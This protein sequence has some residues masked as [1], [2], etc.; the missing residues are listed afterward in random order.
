[1]N[2][3]EFNQCLADA[4]FFTAT[5]CFLL[6]D[7]DC[8][9]SARHIVSITSLFVPPRPNFFHHASYIAPRY[10]VHKLNQCTTVFSTTLPISKAPQDLPPLNEHTLCHR[11]TANGKQLPAENILST[12]WREY[13]NSILAPVRSCTV[14]DESTQEIKNCMTNHPGVYSDYLIQEKTPVIDWLTS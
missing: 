4:F 3:N 6:D 7:P 10:I 13:D 1:M 12:I 2:I 14:V 11:V 9:A 5:K 8:S